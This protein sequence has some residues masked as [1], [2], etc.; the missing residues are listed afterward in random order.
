MRPMHILTLASI[1]LLGVVPAQAAVIVSTT[2]ADDPIAPSDTDL[3]Q[4]ALVS[5]TITGFDPVASFAPEE[6]DLRDGTYN[7]SSYD[8]GQAYIDTSTDSPW[9]ADFILDTSSNALGYDLT[10]LDVISGWDSVLASQ[11]Y[12][13]YVS[14]VG[15]SDFTLLSS[16][17]QPANDVA[18]R[19]SITEDATG[20]L[21]TGVDAIRF[22]HLSDG[23]SDRRGSYREIDAIGTATVPE[24]ASVALLGVGILMAMP[25]A[26]RA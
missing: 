24:P 5:E 3:L 25:R 7:S 12:E 10:S 26:R 9:T 1:S 21:A 23:T 17:S 22:I 6:G 2:T 19:T 20:V 8:F 16:V 13:I 15:S 4:T 11:F 18:L 14:T